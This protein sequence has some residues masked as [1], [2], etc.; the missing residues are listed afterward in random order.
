MKYLLYIIVSCRDEQEE[1]LYPDED[2]KI[3]LKLNDI[4]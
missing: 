3:I 4:L 2:V 1:K